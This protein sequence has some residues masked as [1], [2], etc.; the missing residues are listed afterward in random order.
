MDFKT[1]SSPSRRL[2]IAV[3]GGYR[4]STLEETLAFELGRQLVTEGFN[5]V[6]GGRQGVMLHVARGGQVGRAEGGA[7]I[8]VGIL[9]GDDFSEANPYLDVALPTGMG[10]LRNGLVALSGDLVVAIG[11][12]AGTLSELTLAWQMDKP[13]CFLGDSNW[14]RQWG[15]SVLDE[16]RDDPIPV[17]ARAEQVVSWAANVLQNASY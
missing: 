9:P 16:R 8:L 13:I 15:G 14:A 12:M 17:F 3:I 7:G 11:G 2:N 4:I 1:D 5:I 6:T 10:Y